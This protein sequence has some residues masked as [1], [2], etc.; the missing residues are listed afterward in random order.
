[1]GAAAARGG[2]GGVRGAAPRHAILFAEAAGAARRESYGGNTGMSPMPKAHAKVSRV[3]VTA[4]ISVEPGQ[5]TYSLAER[6]MA[7]MRPSGTS[8]KWPATRRLRV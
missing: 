8:P 7:A 6:V 3:K 4:K 5:C 1:M 2:R